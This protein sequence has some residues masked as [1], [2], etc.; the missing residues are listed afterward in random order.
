MERIIILTCGAEPNEALRG[1]LNRL[2]P[3]CE[4]EMV[5]K[6]ENPFDEC[7]ANRSYQWFGTATIGRK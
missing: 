6:E 4:I 1:W 7:K 5:S 3:E 2:F